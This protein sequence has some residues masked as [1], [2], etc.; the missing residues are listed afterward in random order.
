MGEGGK[1]LPGSRESSTSWFGVLGRGSR[2]VRRQGRP[3]A[4]VHKQ[5]HTALM[6]THS[7]GGVHCRVSFGLRVTSLKTLERPPPPISRNA[8]LYRRKAYLS[9]VRHLPPG[10]PTKGRFQILRIQTLLLVKASVAH[11]RSL[12]LS[13]TYILVRTKDGIGAAAW[14]RYS[15]LFNVGQ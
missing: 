3:E 13:L 14:A 1:Q 4:A 5:V 10:H 7:P 2:S 15:D 8:P 12:C 6:L 9:A 11:N